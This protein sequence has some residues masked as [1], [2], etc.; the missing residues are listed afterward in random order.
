VLFVLGIV[1]GI[2]ALIGVIIAHL[3]RRA[4]AGTPYQSHY[5]N[6]ILVFWVALAVFVIGWLLK[7]FLIGF[8]VLGVLA[9][10]Y[11][12]RTVKGL[13]LASEGRPYA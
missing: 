3:K 13:I 11:L 10:W 12:Y 7:W 6:L 4:A 8:V 9:V 2:T 1:N 5:D